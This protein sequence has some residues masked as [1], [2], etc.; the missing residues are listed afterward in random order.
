MLLALE[1][2]ATPARAYNIGAGRAT[3][4]TSLARAVRKATG[5][6]SAIVERIVDQGPTGLV[7]DIRR[8]RAELGYEP[9][10]S[11][12]EGLQRYVTWLRSSRAD[13]A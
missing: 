3:S 5:S 12:S 8:A 11:L 2:P 9:R 10:V 1:R 4:L 6:Q 13:P 7:A